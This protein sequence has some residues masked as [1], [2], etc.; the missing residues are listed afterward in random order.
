ML[1]GAPLSAAAHCPE[2]GIP[3]NSDQVTQA[4]QGNGQLW[5]GADITVV[6]TYASTLE[7]QHMGAAYRVVGT[8]GFDQTGR[9]SLTS[10]LCER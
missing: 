3:T 8:R 10:G 6:Q 7:E 9:F 5:A 2:S 1:G 4:S